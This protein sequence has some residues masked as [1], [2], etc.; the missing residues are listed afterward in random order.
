MTALARS[1]QV[2]SA[3]RVLHLQVARKRLVRP[4]LR[5]S[6]SVGRFVF[7]SPFFAQYK[8]LKFAGNVVRNPKKVALCIARKMRREVLFAF[9]RTRRMGSGRVRRTADSLVSC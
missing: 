1:L 5:T 4:T 6:K 3:E 2:R 9:K 8:Q 7:R